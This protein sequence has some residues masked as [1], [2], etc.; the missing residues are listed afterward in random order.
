MRIRPL[1]LLMASVAA[2]PQQQEAADRA[3]YVWREYGRQLE[4]K[5][6]V[7]FRRRSR[8]AWQGVA[9]GGRLKSCTVC[10][11]NDNGADGCDRHARNLT[12][13]TGQFTIN[14]THPTEEERGA[15]LAQPP[16]LILQPGPLRH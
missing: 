10:F 5:A 3:E 2:R 11:Q 12:L 13:S 1:L 15:W 6:A 14:I 9:L 16:Q 4:Q 8:W 7:A